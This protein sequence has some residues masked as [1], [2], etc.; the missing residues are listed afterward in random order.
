MMM[1]NS[2]RKIKTVQ[3]LRVE[4]IRLRY[5]MLKAEDKFNDSLHATERLFTIFTFIRNAGGALR[6]AYRI[7]SGVNS[8]IN[9]LFGKKSKQE[10]PS[11]QE[12]EDHL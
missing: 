3:D 11:Q 6:Q 8:F 7:I 10:K 1:I 5:E 9:N 4:K 12:T 2:L